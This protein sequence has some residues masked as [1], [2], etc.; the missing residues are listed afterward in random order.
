MNDIA[1]A[2]LNNNKY[3]VLSTVREDGAPWATPIHIA[4]DDKN[5]Y[6]LSN[7]DTI[8]SIN[9]VRDGRAFLTIFNSQQRSSDGIGGH[10]ALYISTNARRLDGAE[11]DKARTIFELQHPKNK[12]EQF[13]DLNVY[14]AP[15]G[16]LNP[17]KT[18][19]D[20]VYYQYI[21]EDTI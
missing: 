9:L 7:D 8:H 17:V 13:G 16:E 10:G 19:D 14:C 15:I 4:H 2:I 12:S 21:Q 11:A 3:A 20:R 5:V 18:N 6:W 1:K